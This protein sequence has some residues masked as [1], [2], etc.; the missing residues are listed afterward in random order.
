MVAFRGL[1]LK[2]Q[3][4]LTTFYENHKNISIFKQFSFIWPISIFKK[5]TFFETSYGQIWLF[6]F[7]LTRQPC[8]QRSLSTLQSLLA[9]GRIF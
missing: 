2:I 8:S 6:Q 4:E 3:A 1:Y 7:F 9:A 5:W